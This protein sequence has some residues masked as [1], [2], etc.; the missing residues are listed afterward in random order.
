MLKQ[1]KHLDTKCILR[2]F[3]ASKY[4]LPGGHV[5]SNLHQAL[6]QKQQGHP[7]K[8]REHSFA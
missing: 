6:Q 5:L 3:K 7:S 1:I 4:A 2:Y 8:D